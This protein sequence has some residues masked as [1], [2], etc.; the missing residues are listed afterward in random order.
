MVKRFVKAFIAFVGLI[1]P[2][3]FAM[4]LLAAPPARPAP[5]QPQGCLRNMETAGVRVAAY[6]ARMRKP[7]RNDGAEICKQTRLYFL[8]IVKARAVTALCAQGPEREHALGRLDANVSQVN[9]RI[10]VACN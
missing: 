10:A 7:G 3:A 8:E 2:G 1:I 9:R 6:E 4:A 5:F